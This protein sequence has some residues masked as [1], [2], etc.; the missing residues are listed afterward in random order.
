MM[1]RRSF[2]SALGAAV[3]VVALA[4]RRLLTVFAPVEK[5]GMTLAD[6]LR[7]QNTSVAKF[8]MDNINEILEHDRAMYLAWEHDLGSPNYSYLDLNK[9]AVAVFPVRKFEPQRVQYHLGWTRDWL[10][11]H[12]DPNGLKL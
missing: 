6:L 11:K 1:N 2:F 5:P 8:G 9:P 12:P 7:A 4:P 10:K 3:A